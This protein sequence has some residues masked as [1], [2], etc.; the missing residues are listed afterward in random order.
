M[1]NASLDDTHQDL[2]QGSR[3]RRIELITGESR[4][5]CWT[6]EDKARILADSVEPGAK[7]SEV[8]LRHGVN[9]GLLWTWRRQARKRTAVDGQTF[10]PV[11]VV[12]EP[13]APP[14]PAVPVR[15]PRAV[16]RPEGARTAAAFGTID[17]EISGAR[18][19]VRGSVDAS[20][21][22]QVLSHIGR[23]S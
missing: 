1:P 20:A 7:V 2:H 15:Q 11:R 3:Y 9:R 16:T 18:V 5:R 17:I 6:A 8:A 12:D 21:L 10:V 14:T 13:A 19:R 23:G 22:R 4:R